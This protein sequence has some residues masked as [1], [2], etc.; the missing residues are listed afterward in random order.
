MTHQ[1]A[2]DT[3][4][5]ERYL[6]DDM[7]GEDRQ[8]FEDHFF[9]C[10]VCADDLRTAAAMLQGTKEGFA[11]RSTSGHVLPMVVKPQAGRNPAWYRSVAMPWA[12]AATLAV[13]A[14]YQ[15]LRVV[16]SPGRDTSPLALVPVTL[17][18]QSRGAEAVVPI[19]AQGGPAVLA[20]EVNDAPQGGQLTYD[21]STTDGRPIVSGRAA[22]PAPGSPLLLL[23]PSSTLVGPMHYILSV[24]DAAGAGRSLGE[25][26]FA[27]SAQ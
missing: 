11:G 22:A 25:Y 12:V 3:L 7:S 18:P 17:R 4:A 1:E 13:V 23:I 26:R 19:D 15:S 14:G 6:L 2:V 24:H 10:G 21:L 20:I 27:V 8:V 16:P 5:T 9:A